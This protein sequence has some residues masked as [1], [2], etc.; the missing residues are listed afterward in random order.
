MDE[1]SGVENP[2]APSQCDVSSS[3]QRRVRLV[4]WVA[5]LAMFPW[6]ASNYLCW[7]IAY[8]NFVRASVP[9]V[10]LVQGTDSALMSVAF[11]ISD[12]FTAYGLFVVLS[13]MLLQL[14]IP[15]IRFFSRMKRCVLAF[16]MVL[17]SIIFASI[18]PLGAWF[19]IV[20]SS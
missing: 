1:Q 11:F 8:L 17:L 19:W 15:G 14:L 7:V 20:Q 13:L 4:G 12:V 16:V 10:D 2:F 6:L 3:T 18:E 5:C 9:E